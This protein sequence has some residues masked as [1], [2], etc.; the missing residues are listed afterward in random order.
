MDLIDENEN[1]KILMGFILAYCKEN[2]NIAHEIDAKLSLVGIDFDHVAGDEITGEYGLQAQLKNR[3]EPVLLLVSDNFLRST[4]C[5]YQA[6]FMLQASEYTDQIQPV[7][8]NGRKRQADGSFKPIPTTFERVSNVIQYMNYWQ[9]RYLDLRKLKREATDPPL[10]DKIEGQLKIVRST[11]SEVGEFLRILRGVDYWTFDQ[12]AHNDF[13]LFFDTLDAQDLHRKYKEKIKHTKIVLPE[14]TEEEPDAEEFFNGPLPVPDVSMAEDDT[15]N[16]ATES[17]IPGTAQ[18]SEKAVIDKIIEPEL[19]KIS[20]EQIPENII[21]AA[22]ISEEAPVPESE[23]TPNENK[24]QATINKQLT[25]EA[26]EDAAIDAVISELNVETVLKDSYHVADKGP[27]LDRLLEHQKEKMKDDQ[28]ENH[29][30]QNN[31]ESELDRYLSTLSNKESTEKDVQDNPPKDIID[32]IFD[33]EEEGKDIF[34]IDETPVKTTPIAENVFDSVA[35]EAVKRAKSLLTGGDIEEGLELLKVMVDRHPNN[36]QLR[37]L[38][39][40]FLASP[41]EEFDAANVQLELITQ[42]DPTSLDAYTLL[43]SLAEQRQDP[44]LAKS[45][46]EKILSIDDAQ[47]LIQ[48]RL[49][50]LLQQHFRDQLDRALDCF[51]ASLKLDPTNTDARLQYANLL[52]DIRGNTKKAIHE[53][54]NVLSTEPGNSTAYF[55][56]AQVFYQANKR[57]KASRAYHMSWQFDP[58][59]RT[60]EN[61]RIYQYHKKT[62]KKKR[63]RK[64]KNSISSKPFSQDIPFEIAEIK[65]DE[66]G[67]VLTKT[68][69]ITGATSGIGRATAEVFAQNGYRLILTG[70]RTT[71]LETIKTIYSKKFNA[72]IQ[73]LPFDVR[74]PLAVKGAIADL[75]EA[76]QDIDIL[77]NNAGLAKGFG[78]IHEGDLAD[79]EA[80]IDTNIKGLLYMTRCL[81]PL[82]VKRRKGHIINVSSSAGKEVYPN[83]NV[84]CAT[85]HA[86]EALTKAMRL[87]LHQYNIRV[88]QVS[89]GHVEETEFAFVRFEDKEKAKIYEDFQPLRARD[90]AESI[91]FIATRPAH[92]NIQDIH[93][94][95]TQQANSIFI[96]RSG[97]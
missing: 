46:Y 42:Y 16:L 91:Y 81:A 47:P 87:E 15:V 1:A 23:E 14:I 72:E 24:S 94:F 34:S 70:R 50:K 54:E 4:E 9:E 74:D 51:A 21:P 52:F 10:L 49:G 69:L 7:V 39:A 53:L 25:D 29:L 6:L 45:Y 2:Q 56:L 82:M 5:M 95:G 3:K 83:G 43:A 20:E 30:A 88:G 18:P 27:L 60:E 71:R 8:I 40:T 89:P 41:A 64:N 57:K 77:I 28:H 68:V 26:Q 48:Y 35:E 44:L 80:M 59:L 22:K 66:D 96:D 13:E 58:M 73:I 65:N 55:K 12:M 76:W 84:Y 97:R 37:F 17:A 86:V 79:W 33:D 32:D 61:D 36:T 90:V 38:Y 31:G 75:G 92:V 19:E 93:L 85:K 67:A 78:S 11:S 63:K 62:K